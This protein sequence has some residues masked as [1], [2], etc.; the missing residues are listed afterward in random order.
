MVPQDPQVVRD[1]GLR[2]AGLLDEEIDPL[3]IGSEGQHNLETRGFGEGLEDFRQ[4]RY[5][6][7]HRFLRYIDAAI[8]V[9]T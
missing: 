7:I 2:K 1:Q 6:R 4:C 3:S 8:Y 5:R 9:A